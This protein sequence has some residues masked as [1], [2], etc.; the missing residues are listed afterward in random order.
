MKNIFLCFLFSLAFF[1]CKTGQKTTSTPTKD[2][3]QIEVVFLQINDVYEIS[4]LSGQGGLAKVAAFRKKL[5]E[6]NQNVYTL[7]AGDFISPS[8]IGSLKYEDKRIR[9][10]QMVDVLNTMGLD[11][12]CFGNHEF[13]Y[14]YSDLQARLDE[15]KFQW[16]GANLRMTGADDGKPFY[17]NKNGERENCPDNLVWT[18]RDSDGTSVKIGVFGVTLAVNP[19]P[20]VKYGDV[21]ATAANQFKELQP[22]SDVVIGLTHLAVEDDKKLAAQLPGLQLII[23]GHEHDNQ[24][25]KIGKT[26][27]AKADA[28]AKTVYVHTLKFNTKTRETSLKSELVKMDASKPEDSETAAVVAKWEK[29]KLESLSS[30][31]FDANKKVIDLKEPLDCREAAVCNRPSKAGEMITQAMYKF[32][33]NSPDAAVLNAGSIRVDDILTGTLTEL[34]IVRM[35]PFGGSAN[36]IEIRGSLLQKM[37]D[38]GEKNAGKGGY[39]CRTG[40]TNEGGKWL[41]GRG[42]LTADKIYKIILPSFLLTG[43]ELNMEFMKAEPTASGTSNPDILKISVPDAKDKSDLRNDIRLMVIANLRG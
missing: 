43:N 10:R 42:I 26:T 17:K 15:S 14:G 30:L 21:F 24:I 6:T 28:N 31:G 27:V 9:G 40:I 34:D 25:Y 18:A 32:A 29:I 19:Q 3:G 39:L 4:S 7:L 13:D 33:K 37:L 35:L 22:K 8:V 36:E 1:A 2:D 16:L 12:T 11:L 38:A 20:Y 5:K 23:G 41:V